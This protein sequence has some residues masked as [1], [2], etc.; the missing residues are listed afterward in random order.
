MLHKN[1][2]KGDIKGNIPLVCALSLF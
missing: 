2:H 1:I